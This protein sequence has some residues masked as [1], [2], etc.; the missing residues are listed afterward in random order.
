MN[1]EVQYDL[2]AETGL[3]GSM[4]IDNFCIPIIRGMVRC[5][6]FYNS[7][8][9]FIYRSIVALADMSKGVDI[10]TLKDHLLRNSQLEK[11]GGIENIISIL[12]SVPTSSNAK[13]YAEIIKEKSQVRMAQQISGQ[14]NSSKTLAE[15][16]QYKHKLEEVTNRRLTTSDL[17]AML[18]EFISDTQRNKNGFEITTGLNCLDRV[19]MGFQRSSTY[20]IVG[21]TSHGK[22]ALALYGVMKNLERGI[23]V[24]YYT[25][26]MSARK[27]VARLASVTAKLPL[28]WLLYPMEFPVEQE[29]I[30]SKTREIVKR[31]QV[32]N[33]LVVKSF[34][35][36]DEIESDMAVGNPGVI[37]IDFIQNAVDYADWKGY[38]NEEQKL[39]Q[40]S[41]RC[42]TLAE[43]YKCCMVLLSQFAKPVD[44]RTKMVRSIHDIK[45]ASAIG[46]NA[47]VVMLIEY[48]YK[49]TGDW[50][51]ENKATVNVVKNNIGSTENIGLYF[52]PLYQSFDD[53]NNW[54]TKK[55]E[56]QD[57]DILPEA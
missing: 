34:V 19:T 36:I 18:D 3:I 20:V 24:N 52:N 25:F 50:A 10:V 48:I 56:D 51:D 43:K 33:Q 7:K 53:L 8:H 35:S 57:D 30:I 14:I 1:T 23:R 32:D 47:D 44:R 28:K 11:A 37:F 26:D 5:D 22:T 55:K 29:K 54:D 46:Q 21:D 12:E 27:L 2:A 6:D 45:G 38:I 17:G 40:Y 31:Y 15:V 39:R 42:K 13:Y 41:M 16:N 9:G 4:L 49:T